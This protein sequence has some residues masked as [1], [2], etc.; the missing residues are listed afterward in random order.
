VKAAGC[1]KKQF[2]AFLIPPHLKVLINTQS[3]CNTVAILLQRNKHEQ[4]HTMETRKNPVFFIDKLDG[5][6]SR[7]IHLRFT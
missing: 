4:S 1:L 6:L 2:A 5:F 7:N 3:F